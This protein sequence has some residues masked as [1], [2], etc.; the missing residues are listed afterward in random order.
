MAGKIYGRELP[1]TALDTQHLPSWLMMPCTLV[2]VECKEGWMEPTGIMVNYM[3]NIQGS[4][5][6]LQTSAII[7]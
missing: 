6:T 1:F 3:N 7:Q 4:T 2:H 5:A